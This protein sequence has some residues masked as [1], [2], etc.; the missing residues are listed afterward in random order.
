MHRVGEPSAWR[1]YQEWLERVYA[2]GIPFRVRVLDLSRG[3]CRFEIAT[4]VLSEYER[5]DMCI[6]GH[7]EYDENFPAQYC[8]HPSLMTLSRR[9]VQAILDETARMMCCDLV[10]MFVREEWDTQEIPKFPDVVIEKGFIDE[11]RPPL[12]SV[13]N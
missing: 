2:K 12:Q 3:R 10:K 5:G 9:A 4:E 11:S 13:V 8:I 6:V 7:F 1:K